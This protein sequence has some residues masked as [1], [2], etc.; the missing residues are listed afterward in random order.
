MR[1]LD[2]APGRLN[3]RPALLL[4]VLSL[5]VLSVGLFEATSVKANLAEAEGLFDGTARNGADD[6]RRLC[7][8]G[9]DP[10][11]DLWAFPE[12]DGCWH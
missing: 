6:V 11:S 10:D 9:G 8:E 3:W 1:W 2:A 12:D 4:A 7:G 5:A